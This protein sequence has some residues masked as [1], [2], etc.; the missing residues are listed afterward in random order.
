MRHGDKVNNL[1]RTKAHRVALLSNLATQLITHKRIITTLAKAKALRV[2]VEPIITKS[3]NDTLHSRRVVFSKLQSK[4]AIKELFGEVSNK[5]ADRPGG[6]TRIIKLQQRMGDNADMA[7]IELVDFNTTYTKADKAD[8]AKKTRRSRRAN[9]TK[10]S[11]PVTEAA[12]VATETAV[13]EATTEVADTPAVEENTNTEEN[14]NEE[15]A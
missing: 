15:N 1:G 2:Y 8:S 9:S 12:P 7:M 13:A 3:K 6:Y 5:V 14:T 4:E 10:T 11:A